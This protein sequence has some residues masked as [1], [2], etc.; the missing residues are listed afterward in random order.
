MQRKHT[1]LAFEHVK[2]NILNFRLLPGVKISDDEIAKKLGISRTPVREALNRLVEKGLVDYRPNRGFIVKVFNRKEVQD[3][4]ILRD[5][6]E[7]LAIRLA[8]ES[9]DDIKT[10]SLKD[11]LATY[12][13]IIKSKNLAQFSEAD[14][15][16]H[17]LIAQ[18][19]GN[20]ALYKTLVNL[21]GI[22]RVIRRYEHM[23][24]GSFQE[25]YKEHLKILK[26]IIEKDEKAA[27][28]LM[29]AHILNSM[30]LVMMAV[31]H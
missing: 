21:Q 18:Y 6:L 28:K 10:K 17:D 29:S 26:K 14:E 19:S 20:T 5:A 8:I 9:M 1:E 4:Y 13:G 12:P 3:H 11:L 31:P 15:G 16:F 7:C 25:T 23:R 27:S 2:S 30:T 24:M 22:I